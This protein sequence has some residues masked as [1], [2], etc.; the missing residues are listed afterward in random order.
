MDELFYPEELS[1]KELAARVISKHSCSLVF[2]GGRIKG[3]FFRRFGIDEIEHQVFGWLTDAAKTGLIK[4]SQI[5]KRCNGTMVLLKKICKLDEV[6]KNPIKIAYQI[7]RKL[8]KA[9]D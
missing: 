4:E 7:R 1:E 9:P 5:I 8:A 6:K 3:T 2:I